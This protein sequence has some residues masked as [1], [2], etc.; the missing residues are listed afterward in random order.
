MLALREVQTRVIVA[1]LDG[2]HSAMA[3]SL[4]REDGILPGAS[5]LQVYRN[6]LFESLTAALQAVYPVVVK[7]VGEDY[8]RQTARAYI[9][10]HPSC[11]GNLHDFGQ[12]LP[13]FLSEL[14]SAAG[15][16][17]LADVAAL[18]WA[19]HLAYHAAELAP[20]TLMELGAVPKEAQPDMRLHWQ[21]S[22]SLIRSRYPIMAIWQA[23]QSAPDAQ[24]RDETDSVIS[25]DDGGVNVLVVQH[26]LDVEMRNLSEAEACWLGQLADGAGLAAASSTA[27]A[28]DTDFD[29]AAALARH[30]GSGLFIG[31]SANAPHASEVAA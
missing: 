20:I 8:F 12:A 3:A 5:R 31:V 25:L 10:A 13:A 6:N 18:E 7:L 14:E 30:L 19:S 21:P 24:P 15:L 27:L 2:S 22:A 1:L 11:S 9:R 4:L 23:N 26:A 17:Y 29:L 16:P 28:V